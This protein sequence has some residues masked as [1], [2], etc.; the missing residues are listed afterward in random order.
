MARLEISSEAIIIKIANRGG[1]AI[2]DGR[3]ASDGR[4]ETG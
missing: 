4:R 2:G 1:K 3:A